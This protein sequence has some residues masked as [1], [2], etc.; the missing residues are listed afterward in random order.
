MIEALINNSSS[1]GIFYNASPG[2]TK[3]AEVESWIKGKYPG[4][5]KGLE[6]IGK[7]KPRVGNGVFMIDR[8]IPA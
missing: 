4:A 8:R 7:T 3:R 5:W 2:R 1:L 6:K